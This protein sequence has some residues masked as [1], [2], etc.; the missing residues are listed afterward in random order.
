MQIINGPSKA[1]TKKERGTRAHVSFAPSVKKHDGLSSVS[2]LLQDIVLHHLRSSA[3]SS[4]RGLL[5]Y[6]SNDGRYRL[7]PALLMR[8][9]HLL[10]RL[11]RSHSD[12][13]V[14]LLSHG[15][16]H[17]FFIP[18]SEG[19]NI[20]QLYK[21]CCKT[22]KCLRKY[23]HSRRMQRPDD[24]LHWNQNDKR[25]LDHNHYHAQVW[26]GPESFIVDHVGAKQ[27]RTGS[28]KMHHRSRGKKWNYSSSDF[29]ML[30]LQQEEID[31]SGSIPPVSAISFFDWHENDLPS[32]EAWITD[33]V[34]QIATANRWIAGRLVH[35]IGTGRKSLAVPRSLSKED[36]ELL[37]LKTPESFCPSRDMSPHQLSGQYTKIQLPYKKLAAYD[38]EEVLVCRFVFAHTPGGFCIVFSIS[39]TVGDG[40]TFYNI[41]N[42]LSAPEEV[43]SFK[44]TR[45]LDF[46]KN[47][48]E[49]L[50]TSDK[51]FGCSSCPPG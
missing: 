34:T 17:N 27:S 48:T 5:I 4:P 43:R 14:P 2:I 10:Y 23:L 47:A 22:D 11:D 37:L 12:Q 20:L 35:A 29:E 13:R 36:L 8:M 51:A 32:A 25:W 46:S 18:R 24:G 26:S 39:H 15:G 50:E 9:H 31:A 3:F 28:R 40:H 33:R 7:L 45:K 16:G 6:L 38:K 42:Q 1:T 41:M 30:Q 19:I 21:I 49:L 44:P